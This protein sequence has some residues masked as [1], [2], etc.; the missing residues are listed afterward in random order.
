VIVAT[1]EA[2]KFTVTAWQLIIGA[3]VSST[4]TVVVQVLVNPCASVA[5]SVTVFAPKSEQLK[6][7]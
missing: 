6:V 2:S 4:V 1:P 3:N 5:V 7:V